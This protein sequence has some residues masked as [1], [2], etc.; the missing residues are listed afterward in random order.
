M[1]Q[2][3]PHS[4][5]LRNIPDNKYSVYKENILKS[6]PE[7]FKN[8][9]I[10]CDKC[11]LLSKLYTRYFDA[12]IPIDY[13]DKTIKNWYG[14]KTIIDLYNEIINNIEEFFNMGTSYFLQG[15]HGVGK[16]LFSVLIL[17]HIVEKGFCGLYTTLSDVVGTLVHADYRERFDAARELKMIDYLIIDE[18][19]PRFFSSDAS[20]ELYGRILESIIRIRF[21][22]KLPTCLITNNPNATKALGDDL[23]ASIDSLLSG[24]CKSIYVLGGDARKTKG[25]K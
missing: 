6:C 21:Q 4:Q 18:F 16:T 2:R 5:L 23:S 24:Y 8:G 9:F 3:Y 10:S 19:D 11:H 25:D 15:Q 14:H 17:K 1:L 20:A 13:W 22:N 7:C 12:N